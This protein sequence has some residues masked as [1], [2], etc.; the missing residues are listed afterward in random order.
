M[1]VT[2]CVPRSGQLSARDLSRWLPMHAR[3]R[4]GRGLEVLFLGFFLSLVW[5]TCCTAQDFESTSPPQLATSTERLMIEQVA[6]LNRAGQFVESLASL[7]KLYDMGGSSIVEAGEDRHVSTQRTQS[8][9]PL[10]QWCQSATKKLLTDRPELRAGYAQHMDSPAFAALTSLQIE[11]DPSEAKRVASRY[12]LTAAG[13]ELALYLCDLYLE[14]GW[15]LAATSELMQIAPDL[16]YHS[17]HSDP[18]PHSI[19]GSGPWW[20]IWSRAPSESERTRL[21]EAWREQVVG[22]GELI[23]DRRTVELLKRLIVAAT[24]QPQ[25]LDQ[26]AIVAWVR[27]IAGDFT[28]SQSRELRAALD[29][30]EHWDRWPRSQAWTTFAAN[31]SRTA[32]G[33]GKYDLSLWPEWHQQ[34]ERFT[35]NN[36]R[37][38]A[39]KPRV[40]ENAR[41]TLAYHPVVAQGKLFINEMHQIRAYDLVS[42]KPW[43]DVTPPLP[44][45]DSHINSAAY[46]PLGYPIVG[47]PRGTLT[48]AGDCLYARMGTPITGWANQEA[49]EDGGSLSYLVGLDLTKQ[50]SLLRG[51]PLRLTPPEFSG[52]EFEGC[53]LVWGELLLVPI[54]ERDN[55][56]L[57]RSVVAFDRFSAELVWQ[58]AVLASGAVEGSDR[59]NLIT[60]QLL[61][62]AGGRIFYN[63]NLGSIVCLDPLTGETEW[64]TRYQRYDQQKHSYPSPMRFRYRDLTPC[65]LAQGMV[66]CMPQDCAEIF[67]LD[68]YSGDMLW[69]SDDVEVDDAIHLLG[70]AGDSLLV[71]GDRL[72]WLNRRTGE[73]IDRFPGS[74]TPGTV[75][76]LPNPRGMGRGAISDGEVYW[77]T[78]GEVFVFEAD[79]SKRKRAVPPAIRKRHRLDSRGIEGGN[80]T[81][82][83][84]HLV[85]CGP[86]R[87][88]VF[89]R[90]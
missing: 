68:A 60:H 88:M 56:G 82:A 70:V 51:F 63:T 53:P 67:A 66:V 27:S 36:D 29:E 71:S 43:P 86:S 75:N 52:A 30:V 61:T 62:Q 12:R 73:V 24:M 10:R 40:G 39:S 3:I 20:Q 85:F 35:A 15:T 14:R 59:A 46:I 23:D 72:T 49:A 25:I 45:F 81:I 64:L 76:A 83:S 9:I 6:E 1:D 7:Q 58:S 77:P 57:R 2:D 84:D 13:D 31:S 89:K 28:E 8:Y 19:D 44:L 48:F 38:L 22:N 32:S 5:T 87:V 80:L 74:T 4:I 54:V 34:L 79:I 18:T 47:A 16:L 41:G 37:T 42:G 55:V 65:L 21:R 69:S 17:P 50:G 33:E 11:K 90:D 78:A 26:P